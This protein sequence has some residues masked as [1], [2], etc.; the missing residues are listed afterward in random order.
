MLLSSLSRRFTYFQGKKRC[1]NDPQV[2]FKIN[3][4]FLQE[5]CQIPPCLHLIHKSCF[6]QLIQNCHFYC[7]V[8][9]KSL[10]NLQPL[11]EAM[12]VQIDM[13]PMQGKMKVYEN[14][15]LNQNQ[16]IFTKKNHISGCDSEYN[17]QR[18]QFIQPI[19]LPCDR[20]KM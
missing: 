10:L 19:N 20:I 5:P 2:L 8:C 18:L 6:D 4:L 9:S 11:W 16:R 12:K 3:F 14:H 1:Q 17:L 13:H 7:P 15:I